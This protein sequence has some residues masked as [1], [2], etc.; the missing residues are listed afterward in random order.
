MNV[1]VDDIKRKVRVALDMNMESGKL[2]ALGDVDTLSVEEI[3]ESKLETAAYIVERDAPAYLIEGGTTLPD[4]IEWTEG[5][6]TGPGRI[7]LPS[8]FLRLVSF[9]MSDWS[10]SVVDVISE[11]DPVY[12]QQ[13]SRYSGIRGCPQK[14]VVAIVTDPGGLVLEFYSCT[15]GEGVTM[16]RGHYLEVPKVVDGYIELCPRL[17]DAIVYYTAYLTAP[18]SGRGYSRPGIVGSSQRFN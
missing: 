8:D 1:A 3:I 2:E 16:E 17:V 18:C 5:E 12:W 7:A 10:R 11:Q 15:G 6:G 13:V 9:K 14:P 4:A